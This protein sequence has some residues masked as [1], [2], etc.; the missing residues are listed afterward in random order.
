MRC[1]AA[2]ICARRRSKVRVSF[3]AAAAFSTFSRPP[4]RSRCVWSSGA[5][6]WTPWAFSTPRASAAPSRS[7][8]AASCPPPRRC[9]PCIRAGAPLWAS[10]CRRPRSAPPRKKTATRRRSLPPRCVPTG[11]SS[12]MTAC[13][14]RR[15]ATWASCMTRLQRRWTISRRRRPCSSTSRR[16]ALSARRNTPR[17]CA[18]TCPCSCAAARWPRAPRRFMSRLPT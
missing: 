17:S 16:A 6:M 11:K 7:T 1:C 14:R 9:R 18:R 2:A 13:S 10:G 4:I 3:R 15:T 12:A 5:T 8:P